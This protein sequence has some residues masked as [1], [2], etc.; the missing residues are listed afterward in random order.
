MRIVAVA[1]LGALL[2]GGRFVMGRREELRMGIVGVIVWF[3]GIGVEFVQ[4]LV[5]MVEGLKL[6]GDCCSRRRCLDHLG[7]LVLARRVHS[8]SEVEKGRYLF[9]VVLVVVGY[10]L[11]VRFA[12]LHD[13]RDM[14]LAVGLSMV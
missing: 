6:W 10:S 13:P 11:G 9:E 5:V 12:V 7:L 8:L 2:V 4:V 14:L 1:A 3:E